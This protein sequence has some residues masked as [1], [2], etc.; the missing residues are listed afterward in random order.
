[1]AVADPATRAELA[2]AEASL[3]AGDYADVVRRCAALYVRLI[4]ERPDLVVQPFAFDDL[5][6]GGRAPIPARGPW[7]DLLGAALRFD[8]QG[9]PEVVF[10]KDRF[11]MSEAVTYYE[12]TLDTALRAEQLK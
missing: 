8:E 1:M 7:P 11:N 12:Y 9:E 2:E 3:D 6:L 10:E 4:R 5:P